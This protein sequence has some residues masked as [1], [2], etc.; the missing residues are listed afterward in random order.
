MFPLNQPANE[1]AVYD[2]EKLTFGFQ[3]SRKDDLKKT[4]SFP[5]GRSDFSCLHEA[6]L[7]FRKQGS[8]H[9]WQE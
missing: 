4:K 3:I 9:C 5:R 7:A 1:C 6:F 2:S 8:F